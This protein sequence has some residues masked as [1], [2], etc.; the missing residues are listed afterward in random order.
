KDELG[1]GSSPVLVGDA[2]ILNQ[3]HDSE[4]FLLALDK[5]TGKQLWRTDR[6]EFTCG[7]ATPIVWQVNGKKQV[8][9]PGALRV[10]GYDPESGRELWTVRGLARSVHLTPTIG[11]DN[12]LYLGGWTAGGDAGERMEAPSWAEIVAKHDVNKNGTLEKEE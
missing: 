8:V 2:V 12:T 6:S 7:N 3:D 11:P 10:V 5:R 4:S 9:V 1:A